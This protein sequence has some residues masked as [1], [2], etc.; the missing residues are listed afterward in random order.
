MSAT[1]YVIPQSLAGPSLAVSGQE[2][3]EQAALVPPAAIILDLR[4]PDI[5]GLQLCRESRLFFGLLA[6]IN[7]DSHLPPAVLCIDRAP[8]RPP[9]GEPLTSGPTG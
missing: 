8:Y 3:L 4:L 1:T 7:V 6:F 2:G 5:D 9:Y